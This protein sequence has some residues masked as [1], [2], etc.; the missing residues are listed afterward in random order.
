MR[1]RASGVR[2]A[3]G[4]RRVR[5]SGGGGGGGG[6]VCGGAMGRPRT[7]HSSSHCS[8]SSLALSF[9]SRSR[10]SLSPTASI[11]CCRSSASASGPSYGGGARAS[12]EPTSSSPSI[13]RAA[14]V[15]VANVVDALAR[16]LQLLEDVDEGGAA[17]L[18][19]LPLELRRQLLDELELLLLLHP[20]LR[21]QRA[22]V[23]EHLRHLLLGERRL[24]L[25]LVLARDLLDLLRRVERRRALERGEREA[26]VGELRR[27]ELRREELRAAKNCARRAPTPTSTP[28]RR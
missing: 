25:A 6:G 15:V 17:L 19:L 13:G 3:A 26:R 16:R 28:R 1:R 11:T 23:V 10:A 27:A 2:A 8:C 9:S 18:Q 5:R 21:Q 20:L 4:R 24:L 14:A 7:S 12:Y 22:R